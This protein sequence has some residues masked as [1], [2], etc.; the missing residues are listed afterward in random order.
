MC[1]DRIIFKILLGTHK[2]LNEV[3]SRSIKKEKMVKKR[4]YVGIVE[5]GQVRRKD[6]CYYNGY[7]NYSLDVIDKLLVRY[8]A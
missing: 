4:V 7:F 5:C 8:D 6:F 3:N 1:G 2:L